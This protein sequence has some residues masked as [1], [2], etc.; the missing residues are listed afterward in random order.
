M[1]S[2]SKTWGCKMNRLQAKQINTIEDMLMVQEMAVAEGNYPRAIHLKLKKAYARYN[3]M[4]ETKADE[5]LLTRVGNGGEV[6]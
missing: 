3:T 5:T 6:E 2:R 4:Q 1:I